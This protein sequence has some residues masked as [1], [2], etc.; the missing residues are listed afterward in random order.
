MKHDEVLAT[1]L[2]AC[3][4]DF[5]GLYEVVRI[6]RDALG[7]ASA[8]EVR[9]ATMPLLR[10]LLEEHDVVAGFPH[11]TGVCFMPWE[12]SVKLMLDRVDFEWSA[13]G[14][15]PNIGEVVWFT[16]TELID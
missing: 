7:P 4:E 16:C 1:L 12:E 13:L 2:D 14:R 3:D 11:H 8:D 9:L 5:V 10:E 15:D 6:V